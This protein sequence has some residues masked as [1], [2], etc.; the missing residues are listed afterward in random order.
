MR[1]F[2]AIELPDDVRAHLSGWCDQGVS[3]FNRYLERRQIGARLAGVPPANLH[4]TLKFLGQVDES[5]VPELCQALGGVDA[6]RA[7]PLRAGHAELLPPRG[8]VRVVAAGL[9]G[10]V[11]RLARLHREVEEACAACGVPPER[12]AFLPHITLARARE[13]VPR[14]R[15]ERLTES[16]EPYFPGPNFAAEGFTLFES[17]LGGGPP[18][19]VP[20]ARFGG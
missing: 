20:L 2:L 13:P 16:L 10:D 1:L 17:R 18:T 15:R 12:R 3:L 5:A 7:A 11:G 14:E 8:P 4:V 19:Y 6:G 9:D